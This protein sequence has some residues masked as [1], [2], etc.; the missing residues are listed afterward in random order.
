MKVMVNLTDEQ[1]KLLKERAMIVKFGMASETWYHLSQWYYTDA[2]GNC[3][4]VS[5]DQLPFYINDF[6]KPNKNE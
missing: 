5:P 1:L 3:Y 6:F 2:F 4:E